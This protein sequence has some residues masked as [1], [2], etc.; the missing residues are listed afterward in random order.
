MSIVEFLEKWSKEHNLDLIID[1]SYGLNV[2][3]DE[4]VADRGSNED[5]IGLFYNI[6]ETGNFTVVSD[7]KI[8][9]SHNYEIGLLKR[10]Y[11]ET[12]G[13]EYYNDINLLL[14]LLRSL[15]TAIYKDFELMSS[16]Y[17][18]AVDSLD[19]NNVIVKMNFSLTEVINLC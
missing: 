1:T 5:R 4:N 3:R 17:E 10:C 16:T 9:L 19:N 6:I 7:R 12:N 11:K 2:D 8:Q 18:T 14:E 15:F 13:I